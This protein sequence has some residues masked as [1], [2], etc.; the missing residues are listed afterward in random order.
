MLHLQMVGSGFEPP[1]HG[2]SVRVAKKRETLQP[3]MDAEFISMTAEAKN[4]SGV[5]TGERRTPGYLNEERIIEYPELEMVV[6][7][8]P[9]LNEHI[10]IAIQALVNTV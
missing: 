2:F 3:V 6:N 1:T 10:R 5:E 9:D 4:K 8:W 7:R